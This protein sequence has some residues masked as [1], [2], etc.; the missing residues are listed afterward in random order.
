MDHLL[1]DKASNDVPKDKVSRG[2]FEAL[3]A[4][5]DVAQVPL[6][7]ANTFHS[8]VLSIFDEMVKVYGE[9]DNPACKQMCEDVQLVRAH[10]EANLKSASDRLGSKRKKDWDR[11]VESYK[12]PALALMQ[13]PKDLPDALGFKCMISQQLMQDPVMCTLDQR[14]Y[15]RKCIARWLKEKGSSP[16]DSNSRLQPG[17]PAESVLVS[18]QALRDA[19]AFLV[20]KILEAEVKGRPLEVNL[21]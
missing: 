19:I 5:K 16:V 20:P 10:F 18:N 4:P 7:D 2:E 11:S 6:P 12:R 13:E 9:H 1:E 15:E 8:T 3:L 21:G 14:T 17:Q